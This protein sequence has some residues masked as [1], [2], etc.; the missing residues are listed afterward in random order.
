MSYELRTLVAAAVI[1]VL[2]AMVPA[3]QPPVSSPWVTVGPVTVTHINGGSGTQ[4]DELA[5]DVRI[6]CFDPAGA[7]AVVWVAPSGLKTPAEY[8]L[9]LNVPGGHTT[10]YPLSQL[11]CSHN[12]NPRS[13]YVTVTNYG[14]GNHTTGDKNFSHP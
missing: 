6:T 4:H 11:G 13:F 12:L 10:T 3:Q 5:S 8:L 9:V 14:N 2:L 1:A 7:T